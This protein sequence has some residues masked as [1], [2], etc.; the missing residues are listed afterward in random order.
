MAWL[1]HFE[2][3][4]LHRPIDFDGWTDAAPSG[5]T[6]AGYWLTY[7]VAANEV[8]LRE[9][10][11]N[12]GFFDYDRACAAPGPMLEALGRWLALEDVSPLTGQAARF[13]APPAYQAL[14]GEADAL[15]ARARVLFES[16]QERSLGPSC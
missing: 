2:F 10:G 12:V 14:T 4:R 16:L 8:L 9:A 13:I 3:G 6:T 5:P 15:Q 1:G 7:W 11:P